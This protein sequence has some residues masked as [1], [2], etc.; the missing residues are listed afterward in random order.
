MKIGIN[1]I[2]LGEKDLERNYGWLSSLMPKDLS[3]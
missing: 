2:K 3:R 1:G